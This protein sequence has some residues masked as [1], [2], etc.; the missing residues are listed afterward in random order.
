MIRLLLVDANSGGLKADRFR[1]RFKLLTKRRP[2]ADPA[3]T[4]PQKR[5]A[6]PYDLTPG[7]LGPSCN[8]GS[9]FLSVGLR[10]KVQL[11]SPHPSRKDRYKD[12]RPHPRAWCVGRQAFARSC[13]TPLQSR[14]SPNQYIDFCCLNVYFFGSCCTLTSPTAF[15]RLLRRT[16][17]PSTIPS[18]ITSHNT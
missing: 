13:F 2:G 5:S 17:L 3:S 7:R 8:L 16:K 15:Q 11:R 12:L 10:P 9:N 18:V 6:G 4:P 14:K 1:Q